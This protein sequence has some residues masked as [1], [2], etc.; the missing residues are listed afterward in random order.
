M[1]AFEFSSSVLQAVCA[2]A[3]SPCGRQD[4]PLV[5]TPP[6]L[7]LLACADRVGARRRCFASAAVT[8]SV[9]CPALLLAPAQVVLIAGET[10][11]GKTTQ[12]SRVCSGPVQCASTVQADSLHCAGRRGRA[13]VASVLPHFT[14]AA[15]Q[16]VCSLY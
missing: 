12:V 14:L 2:A 5:L 4:L 3:R 8:C 11:C 10:G 7:L 9:C 16:Q 1:F 15:P 13:Y 6:G